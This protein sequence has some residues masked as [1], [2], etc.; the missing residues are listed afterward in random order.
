MAKRQLSLAISRNDNDHLTTSW[1]SIELATLCHT[2]PHYAMPLSPTSPFLRHVRLSNC[3]D[4]SLNQPN[5]P[6]WATWTHQCA[7]LCNSMTQKKERIE[8]LNQ[9]CLGS[10]HNFETR[11]AFQLCCS[12]SPSSWPPSPRAASRDGK[13]QYLQRNQWTTQ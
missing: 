4:L 12:R 13:L 7:Y 1:T 2:M 5:L 6:W 8:D 3:K 10:R 9:N 11:N